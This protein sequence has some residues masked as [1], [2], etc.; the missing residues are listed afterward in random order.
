MSEDHDIRVKADKS[1]TSLKSL[2]GVAILVSI[3]Y[4]ITFLDHVRR[5]MEVVMVFVVFGPPILFGSMCY[6]G[7]K[8][9]AVIFS[10]VCLTEGIFLLSTG[11]PHILTLIVLALSALPALFTIK[12][13]SA[14]K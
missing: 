14:L 2:A 11:G 3:L 10:A 5:E 8:S 1:L 13:W 6:F 4:G 12:A 9:T 7:R